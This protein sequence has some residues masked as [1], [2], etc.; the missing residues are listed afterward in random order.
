MRANTIAVSFGIVA[1]A[2]FGTGT[3]FAQSAERE[4]TLPSA[5]LMRI[6]ISSAT[7]ADAKFIAFTKGGDLYRAGH[8]PTQSR[9]V[10]A[11]VAR[12]A[13]AVLF[14]SALSGDI[15]IRSTTGGA[16][17]VVASSVSGPPRTLTARAPQIRLH[18]NGSIIAEDLTP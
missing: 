6:S 16:L 18:R 14:G 9:V 12:E 2:A 17:L 1:L 3:V 15:V 4:R 7:N 5:N 10:A 13:P 11:T 8:R